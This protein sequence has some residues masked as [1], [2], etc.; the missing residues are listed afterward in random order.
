MRAGTLRETVT[1]QEQSATSGQWGRETNWRDAVTVRASVT[2]T[3]ATEQAET[4][5]V[6]TRTTYTVRLRHRD[7]VTSRHR[8]KH[9]GRT[10]D[11][12]SVIDPDG[13]RRELELTCE[14]HPAEDAAHG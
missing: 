14:E 9:R 13:R 3:A 11:I 2:A 4:Q 12:L 6:T 8:L 1:V 7:D 5:G 10:L